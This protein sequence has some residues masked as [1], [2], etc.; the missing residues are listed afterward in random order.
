MKYEYYVHPGADIQ[1][2]QV[3]VVGADLLSNRENLELLT[4]LGNL[5]DDQLLVYGQK[6]LSPIQA[7]F[8]VQDDIYSFNVDNVCRDETM[9]IDPIVYSTYLAGM[10]VDLLHL[11]L[12]ITLELL[13]RQA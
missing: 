1:D 9:V 2:V 11:L 5:K 12:L 7:S 3:Q 4:P 13:M 10:R 8:Q 6:S